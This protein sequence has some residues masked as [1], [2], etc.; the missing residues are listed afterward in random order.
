[1]KQTLTLL[2]LL[3]CL[4]IKAQPPTAQFSVSSATQCVNSPITFSN[5]SSNGAFP[6]VSQVWDFGDG[7]S[8]TAVSPSHTYT[9]AGT[10][11]V[12]LVVT[13]ANGVADSEVKINYLTVNPA[14][15]ANYSYSSNGCTLPVGIT[16]TNTSTGGLSYNWDFGNGQTST[17][18][19]PTVINYTT[20]G[21]YQVELIT[22]NNF[23]CKDTLNQS[24]L[25]SN[26]ETS[27]IAPLTGCVGSPITL[28]DASSA[29]V[30][31]W[32]WTL[33]GS[34]IGS[35]SSQNPSPIYSAPG[36]Y[37]I[38][39]NSQNT[40]AG[41]SDNYTQSIT[42]NPLPNPSFT[43]GPITGCAPQS[44]SFVNTSI[45][46]GATYVW[47]FGDGTNYTGASPPAHTYNNNGTYTVTLT[48]TDANGC[49]SIDSQPAYVVLVPPNVSFTADVTEGCDP[50]DVQ[51]TAA[52]T[53]LDP[54]VDWTWNFGD[55]GTFSGEIPPIHTYA[56]G[57]FDVSL[58]VTTQSGC[59]TTY[60][61]PE[62][63]AAGH[64][65]LVDF[66]GDPQIQCAK[67]DVNFTDLSVISMPH[68]PNEVTYLWQF[69]DGGTSTQQNPTY[70]YPSDTGYFDV[71]LIVEFRGCFDT[72]IR[73]DYEYILAPISRFTPSQTLFCN[74][75]ALPV[76]ITVNDNSIIGTIPDDADM[77]WD[78]GD[79][80]VTNFDD[81]DFDDADLGTTSHTY[82][83]YGTYTIM[84]IIHNYTT[85]CADSTTAVID[86]SYTDASFL[87]ADSICV[88]SAI[89]FQSTSTSTHPFGT[90][91]WY[92]GDGGYT[93]GS[94]TSYTYWN[95]GTY[96]VMLVATNNVGCRDTAIVAPIT[97]LS[98]PVAGIDPDDAAGCAPFTVTY[99]NLSST[100]GNGVSLQNF[101]FYFPDDNTT[102]NT[103]DISTQVSHTFLL[104]G[105][106]PVSITA[107]DV[108]GCVSAPAY[109]T[110]S[111]TQPNA[112]YYA[113][114]VICEGETVT[115]FNLS[116][117]N[118]PLTYNWYLDGVMV[119]TNTNYSTSFNEA[120]FPL[121]SHHD[122]QL[123]LITTDAN[124]CKDT[125]NGVITVSTPMA[126]FNYILDGA[127]TNA[128]GDF[129]CPPV[130]VDF[131]DQSIN[132]GGI[133]SWF[134]DFGDGKN[135][136]FQSPNNTYVFAGTYTASLSIVDA[137]GCTDDTVLVDYLTIFGPTANPSWT[138]YENT[139]GLYASFDIGAT[140]NVVDI[141]WTL[142][143]GSV[144]NDLSNFTH[145]YSS[146]GT[147]DP[148]VTIYDDNNCAIN[149]PLGPITLA[150][151]P[152]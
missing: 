132:Y 63:V 79:G 33:T 77:T 55:G 136:L 126:I 11:T 74:P 3:F 145:L 92:P 113:D 51:F 121:A 62:Y 13:D 91:D 87:V 152:N 95:S 116:S 40:L 148:Y 56:A 75:T 46:L 66:I 139:C 57:V 32:N 29:G 103:T 8:S 12:I 26:F 60:T 141:L 97:A 1:M 5:S 119:S 129:V 82:S 44:A 22:T 43:G 14:P 65:D 35:S 17:N 108:F 23:G 21:N 38:S 59:I 20:A 111:T 18:Q 48:M 42:I 19:N 138:E 123:E 90:F 9:T 84:Q 118:N 76:T 135:S 16:F 151:P 37:S 100:T 124:G 67:T 127:A 6:I 105:N 50:L 2:F 7:T 107:T 34:T 72:L 130:F 83:S 30:N 36:T 86:V 54:I 45:L 109:S 150:A 122:H 89:S 39:L 114:N 99:S 53:S 71:T 41:C 140:D 102:Q 64:I 27:F 52:S 31:T 125:V 49:S 133:S 147:Y 131:T 58:T 47:D 106:F 117:G 10:Y 61:I 94:S 4:F 15:N 112:M 144:V 93:S 134:W 143:D 70:D 149:Y 88:G 24:I 73:P 120:T 81:P 110:I 68:D 78:W 96:S 104:N 115:A 146:V 80:T 128:N 69:G 28:T 98:L 25:I 101:S 137:Y 142:D 85:G